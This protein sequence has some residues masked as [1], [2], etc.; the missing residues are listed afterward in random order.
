MRSLG[1]RIA[2]AE[3][4]MK[5]SAPPVKIRTFY[6]EGHD[7][8]TDPADFL[9]EQGHDLG[10]FAIICKRVPAENGKPVYQPYR[11]FTEEIRHRR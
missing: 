7:P 3:R 5:P 1:N 6:V 10:E 4:K 9:R 11:D 2:R 8:E